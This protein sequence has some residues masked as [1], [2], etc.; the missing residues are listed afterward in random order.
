[1][2]RIFIID[3]HAS[4]KQ[5]GI[6]TYMRQLTTCLKGPENEL[7][8]ISFNDDEKEFTIV[9]KE[10]ITYYRFPI[11]AKGSFGYNGP[12]LIP[13]LK[14]YISD[15]PNNVFF[16]NHSPCVN[17]LLALKKAY[18][19]SKRVFTIHNQGWVSTLLGDRQ[20]LHQ[21][22][23]QKK[24]QANQRE[25][26]RA[27]LRSFNLEKKMYQLV[28][29]VVCL[30]NDT[31][32]LLQEVYRVPENKIAVIPNGY[33]KKKTNLWTDDTN[34]LRQKLG[35]TPTEKIILYVGRTTRSKGI[36]IL[37]QAFENLYSQHP[38]IRLV[39]AGQIFSLNEFT[40]LT[41]KSVSHITYTGLISAEQLNEWYQVADIGVLPSYSE[42]CSYAGIE[43]LLQGLIIV[44][45]DAQ[46]IR[47]M[48]ENNRN[49]L[50]ASIGNRN[51]SSEFI[52]SLTTT[53]IKAI[54]LPDSCR[55]QLK[56]QAYFD[57]THKYTLERMQQNYQRLLVKLF[58]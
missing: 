37:L 42:Q 30:S 58:Q 50:I 53:L 35:L 33:D 3:E 46:G 7:N 27:V 21:I 9:K 47:E 36:E 40:R 19:L 25:K 56:Q 32:I 10:G 18:P 6:G 5:N 13:I 15:N 41:P 49:A 12:I 2:K 43:M 45:T 4:S 14:L 44:T 55:I 28:H 57:A 38:E 48:F 24:I 23:V 17:F 51:N 31:N 8:I 20:L 11:C 54:Q 22:I 39:I 16:V 26:K 34:I 1:M 52:D 29:A